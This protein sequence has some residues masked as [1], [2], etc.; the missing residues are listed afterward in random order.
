MVLVTRHPQQTHGVEQYHFQ[1]SWLIRTDYTQAMFIR[2]V[3][4][5]HFTLLINMPIAALKTHLQLC[6]I[7]S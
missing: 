5:D 3:P 2:S 7:Q 1:S 4:D 6:P